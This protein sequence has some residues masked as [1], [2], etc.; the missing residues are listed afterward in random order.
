MEA[1]IFVLFFGVSSFF[2]CIGALAEIPNCAFEDTV[3]LTSSK[4]FSNGSYLYEG[5]LVPPALTGHYDYIELYGGERQQVTKH[6]RGCV[7][8]LKQCVKFC[9][10]PM[11]GMYRTS[12]NSDAQCD[13]KLSE[14]LTYSPYVN[15]TLRNSS[16]VLMHV[17]DE[18]VVQQGIPCGGGYML[19]P[20]QYEEDQWELFENGTLLRLADEMVFTRRDYCLQAYEADGKYVMNPMNCPVTYDE[21]STLML[22]TIVMMISAPFLYATILIYSLIP[23]LWN[24]HTKCLI[25]YLSSLAIGTTMIAMINILN[26]DYV[27]V[28]CA[29]IGF[30]TYYFL[31]AA[32]FWLNVICFDL[33]HNF[34]GTKGNIQN[35]TQRKRFLYYALYAWGVPALMTILTIALQYSDL[36]NKLKSGIGHSHCWL[37]VDDWS[38]MIY[39]HGPC[40]LLIIFN[41]T[42]FFVTAKKIYSIRKE[43][44]KFAQGE[45][46]RRHLR[47]QQNE[48]NLMNYFSVWLFFRMFIVMGIGWLLEII[49]YIVGDRS[50]YAIIFALADIYNASQ[51]LIIFVLLVMK[52]KVLLLIKRRISKSDNA[53]YS[54]F[55]RTPKSS[56]STMELTNVESRWKLQN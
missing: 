42:I 39:F 26:S 5:V 19:M 17:L 18:F 40:L 53:L 3:N 33:W 10:H 30:V 34:R 36:P 46:S 24:L 31:S 9:C 1:K 22:N 32:F 52:K 15:V 25:C 56:A 8:H 54:S 12:E 49:G 47:S 35:L 13:E 50:D 16:Q 14:E 21:P 38:A 28:I 4:K 55:R 29:T 2:C 51:G 44:Q 20:H 48:I 27:N 11:A 6:I 37:K 7:C 41:I 45:E 43:L 23:E